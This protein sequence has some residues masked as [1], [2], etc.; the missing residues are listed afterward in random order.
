MKN[1]DLLIIGGVAVVLLLATKRSQ[2]QTTAML[3]ARKGGAAQP[4]VLYSNPTATN[5]A[6]AGAVNGIL[7]WL[8]GTPA[9]TTTKKAQP[10]IIATDGGIGSIWQDAVEGAYSMWGTNDGST[11]GSNPQNGTQLAVPALSNSFWTSGT[12]A[13]E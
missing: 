8:S 12:G 2:A 10:G 9:T 11:D 7:N 3:N 6:I 4:G 5:G 13:L 1:S